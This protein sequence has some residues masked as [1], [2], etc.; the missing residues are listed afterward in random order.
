MSTTDSPAMSLS[1]KAV[2]GVGWSSI[3]TAGKQVLSV[4]SLATVARLLGPG[5][6]GIMGMAA[7][8]L[9]FISIVRDMGTGT[10]IVQRPSITNRLLSTLFWVNSAFG[11]LLTLTVVAVSPLMARFFGEPRL[12]AILST[13]SLSLSLNSA[14]I[15][16]N[17]ILLRN[18]QF[19]ALAVADL[20]SGFV[21]YIVALTCAYSGLGVWSL[22]Y[23][24][25]ANSFTSTAVYWIACRWRPSAEFDGKELKG[26]TRFSL[27][28]SGFGLVNYFARNSDNMIVGK[29]LG[30][31]A[32]GNYQVAYNLML[33][34]LQNVSSVI[35][36]VTLPAF[37]QIQGD[38]ARFRSA[39]LR[40]SSI[41]SLLTFPMMA[42][43]GVVAD[44]F[45]R[46]ILGLKWTA[47]IPVFQ[48]LAPVGLLQSVQT[49][50]G[51][52]YIAKARTDWMFRYGVYSCVVVVT[53]F[54]IGVRFGTVGRGDCLRHCVFRFH[55]ITWLPD[56]VPND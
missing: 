33:T 10:A 34:P 41:I 7:L 12:I 37:S 19:K 17:S 50:V 25:I 39:Y 31:V 24:N 16:H 11:L 6:Y 46:A 4:L 15:V 45:I 40:S 49:L 2:V 9:V 1:H 44:P 48:I 28:L 47:A 23:A 52:I 27:N 51:S 3:S 35:A 5:A 18:M 55:D 22:V 54:L 43:L 20:G 42:G 29:V 30:P 56:S 21:G 14:G 32:L 53:A 36:Q 13:I 38:N 26:V 8:L